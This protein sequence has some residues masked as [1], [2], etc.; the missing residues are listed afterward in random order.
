MFLFG[1]EEKLV[2]AMPGLADKVAVAQ[3]TSRVLRLTAKPLSASSP[4]E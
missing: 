4:G 3:P 2:N 1:K